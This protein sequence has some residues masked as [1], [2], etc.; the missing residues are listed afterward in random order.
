MRSYVAAVAATILRYNITWAVSAGYIRS[1]HYF[2]YDD[3]Q[4]TFY[5]LGV[6]YGVTIC[7]KLKATTATSTMITN[8]RNCNIVAYNKQ[9]YMYVSSGHTHFVS[10]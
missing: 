10:L 9:K 3:E 6:Q 1:A 4:E 7:A 8:H 2:D 5:Y